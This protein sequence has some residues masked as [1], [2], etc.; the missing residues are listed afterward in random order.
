ML[1]ARG[2]GGEEGKV[3]VGLGSEGEL[4]LGLLGG[5][6]QALDHEP[7]LGDVEARVLLELVDKVLKDGLIEVLSAQVSVSVGALY[8]EDA[9]VHLE[10]GHIEGATAEIVHRNHLAALLLVHAVRKRR[11]RRLVDDAEHLETSDLASIL[12][13]LALRVVEVGRHS[14]NSLVHGAAQVSIG[15]LLHLEEHVGSDLRG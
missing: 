7:V 5:L 1:R 3:D 13:G 10:H 9:L 2:V 4:A 11:S 6:A 12:G 14:H 15:G 8:L